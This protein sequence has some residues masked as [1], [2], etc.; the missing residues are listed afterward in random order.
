MSDPHLAG[1]R[2]T[3]DLGALK[4]NYR[5]LAKRSGSA[6]CAAVVKADAYGLG[7]EHVVPALIDSG[8]GTFFVALPQEGLAVR[9]VAPAARIFVL[10]GIFPEALDAILEARLIPV[11]SSPCH[12][13]LWTRHVRA[14]AGRDPSY[15]LHVDTGMNRL[16]L[17][18]DEALALAGGG[19][20]ERAVKPVHIMSHLACADEPEHP[21]NRRQLESFQRVAAA[22]PGIESSLA[23]SAGIFL[24]PDYHFDLT[25]P[26]IALYGGNPI[27]GGANPMRPVATAE[28][29][30]AQI[31]KAKAGETVSYGAT[32]TLARDTVIAVAQAGYA[33]GYHRAASA[34]GVVLRRAAPHGGDGFIAGRKVPILGR[35]TM[36]LTM[37]DIT[38]LPEGAV[39][40]GDW[41]ELFGRNIPIDEAAAAAGTI[42]YELLTSLGRRARR[43]YINV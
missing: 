1:H 40:E 18:L 36:D 29:R 24:G 42:S 27:N 39:K 30:I 25:R 13:D 34:S 3:I 6:K 4:A 26:G 21:L 11:L 22:F 12:T 43:Q 33:D 31:R 14:R 28:A 37:F 41:I 20:N 8:C 10:G 17:T 19:A 16:G 9:A 5:D 38:D 35:V 23:N 32:Q 2:L 7:V 15:A